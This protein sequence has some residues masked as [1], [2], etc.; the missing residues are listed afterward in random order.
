MFATREQTVKKYTRH[1]HLF[2]AASVG[3]QDTP[4]DTFKP[5]LEILGG[6]ALIAVLIAVV[7][8]IVIKVR[9]KRRRRKKKSVR[10]KFAASPAIPPLN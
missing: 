5:L 7:T 3:T 9:I 8:I 1:L 10:R 6:I 4:A 2:L